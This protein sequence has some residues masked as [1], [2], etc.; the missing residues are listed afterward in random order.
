MADNER[1]SPIPLIV[2][3]VIV[4]ALAIWLGVLA[5]GSDDDATTTTAP[6]TTPETTL[7]P[8]TTEAPTTTSAPTTTAPTS[9]SD[10]SS[11]TS[12]SPSTTSPEEAAPE[13]VEVE[14][15]EGLVRTFPVSAGWIVESD[16]TSLTVGV[17]VGAE[18]CYGL[19][20]AEIEE[21]ADAVNVTMT[22]GFREN[23]TNCSEI[24][25]HWSYTFDLESPLGDRVVVDTHTGAELGTEPP[26]PEA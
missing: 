17:S 11:D 21:T 9:T 8:T 2:A 13:L 20:S 23:A 16:D 6:A 7:A 24:G 22:A 18:E 25:P 5:F 19:A 1:R 26:D 4:V 12:S 3:G 14:V 10:T 15:E